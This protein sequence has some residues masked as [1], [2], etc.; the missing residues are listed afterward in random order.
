MS[1]PF[2][3]NVN[4]ICSIIQL[5]Y[6]IGN[7]WFKWLYSWLNQSLIP[8]DIP[9]LKHHLSIFS[10]Q[11]LKKKRLFFRTQLGASKRRGRG[12]LNQYISKPACLLLQIKV[13]RG[14]SPLIPPPPPSLFFT[15]EQ[16]CPLRVFID[17]T[18][19][20]LPIFS[21]LDTFP[22][23]QGQHYPFR[24]SKSSENLKKGGFLHP[25]YSVR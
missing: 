20:F 12:V 15:I 25:P 23:F 4:E 7:W 21:A 17:Q 8:I 3:M 1:I 22:R 14:L 11:T 6:R 19:R 2:D 9:A 18:K 16:I 13:E 5:W 24:L 10:T